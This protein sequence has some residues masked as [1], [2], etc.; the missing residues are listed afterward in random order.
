MWKSAR[1]AIRFIPASRK[2]LTPPVRSISSASV[3]ARN[4]SA[5]T[6]LVYKKW[7]RWHHFFMSVPNRFGISIKVL[8][9]LAATADYVDAKCV[10]PDSA[11]IVT[12]R[13]V[14]DGDTLILEDKRKL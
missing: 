2:S 10:P 9:L 1:T 7:C 6:N 11:E 5:V 14:H 3:T 4:K 8:L 12:V 13:H